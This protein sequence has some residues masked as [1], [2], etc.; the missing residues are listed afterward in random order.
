ML[1]GIVAVFQFVCT[2]VLQRP[3]W[4][5]QVFGWELGNYVAQIVDFLTYH[6][7]KKPWPFDRWPRMGREV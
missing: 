5:V 7:E 2:L 4:N 3:R 1:V 6:S